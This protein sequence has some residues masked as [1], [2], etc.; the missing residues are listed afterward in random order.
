MG[1][2]E[3]M[4]ICLTEYWL[5][6]QCALGAGA[7]TDE[8]LAYFE[9]PEK[10]YNAGSN[11][12]RLSGLLTD[13]KINSLKSIS[14][15]E[16][17]PIFRECKSKG[18]SIITP[19]NVNYPE[20]FK[21]L[22]DMPLALY[23]LGDAS[24][25]KDSVSIG[26]VGTRNA[27]NYGIETAQKLSFALASCGVTIVS[28]GA[29]GIDS[30][31]HAGAMLAKG[32]TV[33]FLG[34]G[35]SFDYLKENA[36]LR[37]A[38]TKYGAVVSEFAPFTSASRTTFPIRNRLISGL[39]LGTVVIEAGIKS[40]SLITANYALE[41]GKDVFAVP[42]DIVRSSFDG[43]NHLI[44]NGAKPVFSVMD[45]L[46]E[47]EY[48]YGD[49]IDFSKADV[50]LSQL[51]YVEYRKKSEKKASQNTVVKKEI[52]KVKEKAKEEVKEKKELDDSFSE[53]AKK[54]YSVLSENPIHVDDILRK[55][56]LKMNDVL[57]ALTELEIMGEIVSAEGKKYKI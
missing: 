50:S 42:G 12:W 4:S 40:G 3:I 17:G 9:T 30:E 45:I 8:L 31:A 56:S 11:E 33:A 37:R 51:P 47:Y 1:N 41:Q 44:K 48:L 10:M 16:T 36:S 49:L 29:L 20:R 15:S 55:T 23:S 27:S 54:V 35:L 25:L 26:I 32:R 43:A 7:K 18:Y 5:W 14:P 2:D 6:L 52:E 22:K 53:D 21:Q 24:V 28:G 38:I 57:S 46:S 13:K 34:C 19:D 39:T